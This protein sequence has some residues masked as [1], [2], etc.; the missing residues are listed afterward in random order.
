[1]FPLPSR[2]GRYDIKA[3]I[4]SGGM[5]SLYLARDT[6]PNTNRLVVLK[7]LLTNLDSS[8]LRERFAREARALAA[9]NHPNI[10]D[11]YDSGEFEG[12]PFI[13]MEY[14]RGETLAEK[15]ARGA[16][17]S[18]AQKLALM[19]EMCSGLA[20]AH[21]AGI[22][23]RDVK[24]AN[25]MVDL[26]GR[27]K[28][29]DFGIARMSEGL[30]ETGLQRTRL[31][32][33]IGTPGYMPPE[34]IEGL[35]IDRRTD[36][37][38]VGSVCY[39]LLS[40]RKAFTGTTTRQ[41]ENQVLHAQPVALTSLVE[42]LDPEIEAVVFR[43]L[44]KDRNNRYQDVSTIEAALARQRWRMGPADAAD[45]VQRPSPVP[46]PKEGRRSG[47][48]RADAAYQRSQALFS[49][50][51]DEAARRFAIEAL[52]ENPG[53]EDARAFLERL[54][55]DRWQRTGVPPAATAAP[56]ALGSSSRPVESLPEPP[57]VLNTAPDPTSASSIGR[58]F[59]TPWRRYGRRAQIAAMAGGVAV[60]VG[61]A[62]AI[63]LWL[64]PGGHEL[65][66]DPPV[67][68]T[69]SGMGIHCGTA[70]ADC[71]AEFTAGT[72]VEL[73]AEADPG[74]VFGGFNGDCAQ[75]GRTTMSEARRCGATFNRV[76]GTRGEVMHLLDVVKPDHGTIIGPGIQ[77]G[78]LGPMCSTEHPQGREI[79]LKAYADEG[80]AFRGFAGDC[81]K[82][83]T[84]VM[85][86][87]RRC[88]AIFQPRP[89]FDGRIA[90]DDR[91]RRGDGS[92]GDGRRGGEK[93]PSPEAVARDEIHRLLKA[94]ST[95]YERL[96]LEGIKRV[97][98][99]APLAGLRR[100][101]NEYKSAEYTY[102]GDFEFIDL[103][104]ALGTATVKVA[105]LLTPQYKGPGFAPQK[106]V[107]LFKLAR[108]DGT[109]TI[110][111]LTTTQR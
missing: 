22:I 55:P 23:H 56:T 78:S 110:R 86:G 111:E 44:E 63:W 36:V 12:S 37:F 15:I 80:F 106:L 67:G 31:N 64:W 38:A 92:K 89:A 94:Y 3:Q 52:A 59:G 82:D 13:V 101:F 108:H 1:M 21:E 109:W 9:L 42:S 35:E 25:L 88:T 6:N 14:V 68:G 5:G 87:P 8:E 75:N 24:P 107:N 41:I 96:D 73:R 83:G 16:P 30:T 40:Y 33:R 43:A 72:N 58:R 50:G 81:L 51:A 27:L 19:V 71:R 57:T 10:V 47:D 11:I 61:I 49:E 84:L 17:M 100:A 76:A 66:I 97:F 77:C 79:T 93:G 18:M 26:H 65:T 7:L 60:I 34:Q 20:H 99:A 104:A 45:A 105:A 28:I 95:A 70:T 53:H 29:L 62:T 102:S 2:I 46:I 103:D 4:G 32:V 98:P 48:A 69:I 90:G 39:E 91:G 74:F 85:G 54:D